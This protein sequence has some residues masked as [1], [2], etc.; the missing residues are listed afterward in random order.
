MAQGIMEGF[1]VEPNDRLKKERLAALK[2]HRP[3]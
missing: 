3:A 2:R 1:I